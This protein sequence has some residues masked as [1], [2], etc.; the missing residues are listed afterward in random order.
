M[1]TNFFRL[2][3]AAAC[4]G[5]CTTPDILALE[6]GL[7]RTPPMGFNTWNWFKCGDANHGAINEALIKGIADAMVSSGMRDSG[8]QYV[9]IDDCWGSASR[10]GRGGI[11]PNPQRFPN[12]M[13]AVADYVHSKGLKLGLYTDVANVT[14]AK[15][16]PGLQGHENQDCDT[17]VAWG[18][19]YVKVD[20]CNSNGAPA[21][22]AYTKV[23]DA[24]RG[25]VTRMK[26]TVPTAHEICFSICNWGEQSP[27]TWAADIGNLW[28]TTGDIDWSGGCTGHACWGGIMSTMDG[29]VNH[30]SAAGPGHWNDPDMLEIGNNGTTTAEDRA[31]FSLWAMM[32][33]PLI[34]GNDIRNMNNTTRDILTNGEVIAVDQDSLGMQGRRIKSGNSEVWVKKLLSQ[35]TDKNDTN[36]AVLFFNRNNGGPVSMSITANE[37][38]NAV[39]GGIQDGDTYLV[40]D[41]WGH[42]DLGEW[43]AGTYTTPQQVGVHDVFMIR[44]SPPPPVVAAIPVTITASTELV[45]LDIGKKIVVS[46]INTSPVSVTMVDLKGSA[47]F[48]QH[49]IRTGKCSI[50][51]AGMPKGIYLVKVLSGRESVV[52]KV[53]LR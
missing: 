50:N 39:A 33:A 27:W 22:P 2:F 34:A 48:A 21:E 6:N 32:A 25:A 53:V 42:K 26:P 13:K 36:Y 14:C 31:H 23:R 1:K 4:V 5:L 12:G 41:L 10:D 19:D 47:V 8:Y 51:I 15:S 45:K 37:I 44:L 52:R 24:L 3:L 35:S 43:K 29:T 28:R 18:I 38:R 40:R 9:N 30:W 46:A 20:W 11:I 16:M 17:F 7:A 49:G